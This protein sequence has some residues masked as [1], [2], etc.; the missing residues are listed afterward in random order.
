M[1][2]FYSQGSLAQQLFYIMFIGDHACFSSLCIR[3]HVAT[4]P[5]RIGGF[6]V[7][8]RAFVNLGQPGEGPTSGGC[9]RWRR[10]SSDLFP[11]H[12]YPHVLHF[13]VLLLVVHALCV[14][15]DCECSDLVQCADPRE[16]SKF[17]YIS[18]RR[19][20]SRV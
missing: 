6:W 12:M 2:P 18:S 3:A 17:P 8:V 5:S 11:G 19:L 20:P 7:S 16:K 4:G 14:G 10:E 13:E 9:S 15:R 1:L